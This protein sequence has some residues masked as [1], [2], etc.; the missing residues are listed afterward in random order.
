MRNQ[1]I[2]FLWILVVRKQLRTKA[3]HEDLEGLH[4]IKEK[5][6]R[7]VKDTV[8]CDIGIIELKCVMGSV[9]KHNM[10]IIDRLYQF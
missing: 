7:S 6:F 2:Q 3:A 10:G 5:W 8:H 4:F 9:Q 1:F